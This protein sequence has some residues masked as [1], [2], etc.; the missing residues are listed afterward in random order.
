[1][2]Q[3][4]LKLSGKCR[5]T[6]DALNGF[7]EVQGPGLCI[8]NFLIFRAP[9][10][11]EIAKRLIPSKQLLQSFIIIGTASSTIGIVAP[12]YP[13]KKERSGWLAGNA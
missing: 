8:C 12:Y 3:R 7:I 6:S 2:Q 9:F 1:M 5:R 11:N 13:S 10:P 4:K